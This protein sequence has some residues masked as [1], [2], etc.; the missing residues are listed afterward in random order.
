VAGPGDLIVDLGG[1]FAVKLGAIEAVCPPEYGDLL[2]AGARSVGGRKPTGW[3]I[4]ASGNMVPYFVTQQEL[5]HALRQVARGLAGF[6][7]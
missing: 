6:Q 4:L 3:L 2:G 5:D 7:G 1:N